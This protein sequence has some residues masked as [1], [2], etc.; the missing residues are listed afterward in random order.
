MV[1]SLFLVACGGGSD[2]AAVEEVVEE[3]PAETL[4][5]PATTAA[6]AEPEEDPMAYA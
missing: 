6:P 2:E 3:E 4:D 1:F 5:A